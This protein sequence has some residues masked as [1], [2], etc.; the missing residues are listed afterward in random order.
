MI[1]IW[2]IVALLIF[3]VIILIHEL[4]HFLTS[5]L[6]WVKVE[7]FWLW[8]PPKA[9]KLFKDKYWT[10]YTLNWLPL[11]WFVRLKWENSNLL[12]N[13]NDKDALVNKPFFQQIII[14][15]A[16]VVMNFILAWIIFSVLFF[17]WVKPIWINTKIKTNLDIKLIPNYEQSIKSWLL[18]VNS[19]TILF[20]VKWSIA[21]NSWVKEWDII[22][23]FITCN[24]D[25]LENLEC[26]NSEKNSIIKINNS[27]N[28]IE[29]LNNFKWKKIALNLLTW[30]NLKQEKIIFIDIPSEW[31]IWAYLS[32]NIIPNKEFIY[33][34]SLWNSIKYWFKEMYNQS[35]LTFSWLKLLF[36]NIFNPETPK[37]RQEAI[38]QVSWPI[39]IV[40][41]ISNSISEWFVFLIL[42][43]AI[44]SINLWIF[45]LLPIPAL[46][47]WR[48]LFITVNAITS[49]LFWKK[50][51]NENIEW[52]IHVL[53]FVILIA[54]SLIIAYNDI[55]K[56]IIK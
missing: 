55:Y 25:I 4:W 16:W 47:W 13:K 33:K 23:S 40:D 7:E 41:F 9:K 20:P 30:E 56:I 15:L 44:I 54:L 18:K 11:W 34:Y 49:K 36:K 24:S 51:I 52:L 14:I 19:W 38:N 1:I 17:V 21:E 48:F 8:I 43:W 6:F 12:D 27:K 32:D 3:T 5:R 45:N 28:F 22:T 35:L 2:I 50:T 42:I 46:D 10:I 26:L 53:F 31:K 29:N 39:W 37:E